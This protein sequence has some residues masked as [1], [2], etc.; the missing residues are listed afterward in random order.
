MALAAVA[1][2]ELS[3]PPSPVLV[4]S[5]IRVFSVHEKPFPEANGVYCGSHCSSVSLDGQQSLCSWCCS[6]LGSSN[7]LLEP[8]V[9]TNVTVTLSLN[10]T[11]VL[12]EIFV[13]GLALPALLLGLFIPFLL[14][15]T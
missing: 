2:M 13:H 9:M 8:Y 7:H 14:F 5:Q 4:V 11:G 10:I 15:T 3:A 6:G 12:R 1:G